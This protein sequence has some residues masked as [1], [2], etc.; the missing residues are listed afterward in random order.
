MIIKYSEVYYNE[1]AGLGGS[2]LGGFNSLGS[3]WIAQTIYQSEPVGELP[4]FFIAPS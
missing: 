2:C 4:V 3:V 1:L